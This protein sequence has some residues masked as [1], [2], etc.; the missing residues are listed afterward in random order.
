LRLVLK[1]QSQ[2][3]LQG[4]GTETVSETTADVAVPTTSDS[5]NQSAPQA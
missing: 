4:S 2:T 1:G 5:Q 3:T